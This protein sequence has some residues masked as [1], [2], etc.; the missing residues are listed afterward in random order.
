MTSNEMCGLKTEDSSFA[1]TTKKDVRVIDESAVIADLQTRGLKEN[2]VREKLDT[3]SFKTLAK[4]M[5]KETGEIMEGTELTESEYI[6]IRNNKKKL[7]QEK[8]L[9][10]WSLKSLAKLLQ[11][12]QKNK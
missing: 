1:F 10:I 5:L 7:C 3:L 12:Y 11:D 2:Y 8:K 6:S 4:A 9:L